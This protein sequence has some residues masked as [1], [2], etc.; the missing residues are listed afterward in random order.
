MVRSRALLL[1]ALIALLVSSVAGCS[2]VSAPGPVADAPPVAAQYP[3]WKVVRVLPLIESSFK[4]QDPAGR[5]GVRQD[6]PVLLRSANGSTTILAWWS[7]SADT[8]QSLGGSPWTNPDVLFAG[9]V[10]S[11]T[12]TAAMRAYRDDHPDDYV[13]GG[14]PLADGRVVLG[15]YRETGDGSSQRGEAVLQE[16]EQGVWVVVD[17]DFTSGGPWSS[18]GDVVEIPQAY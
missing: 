18:A 12:G 7:R 2:P 1:V 17:S 15:F 4:Q 10:P 3:G 11:A 16:D 5:S 14:Y 6:W 8:R 13:L 9:A